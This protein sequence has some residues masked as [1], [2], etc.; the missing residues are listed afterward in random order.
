[1]QP[2]DRRAQSAVALACA[3]DDA[4]IVS[5]ALDGR[6]GGAT[7]EV[8]GSDPTPTPTADLKVASSNFVHFSAKMGWFRPIHLC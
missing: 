1:M 5:Y 4:D 2:Q 6:D 8:E 7:D 3:S